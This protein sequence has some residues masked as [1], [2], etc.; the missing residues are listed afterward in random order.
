MYVLYRNCNDGSFMNNFIIVIPARLNSTRLPNKMM[1]LIGDKPV[2]EHTWNQAMLANAKK[3]IVATDDQSI[4]DHMQSVGA[5][6]VMTS[7]DHPTGTDRLAEVAVLCGFNDEDVIVN[8]Q[9]DEPFLPFEFIEKVANKLAAYPKA[10]MSTLATRIDSW[11]DFFNVNVVKVVHS[12][13]D[14]ALYFSRAPIPFPRGIEKGTGELPKNVQPLRHIGVYGYRAFF[15]KEYPKLKPSP[16]EQSESLE[17][18]RA[19]S[20]GYS[21]VIEHMDTIPPVGIDTAAEL[22]LARKW[23]NEKN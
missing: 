23:Y 10:A 11:E 2:I 9:G 6:V 17:Q 21:I 5:E 1:L 16:L 18:L 19:L 15:L 13:L 7:K 14:E 4:F 3:V 22:E 12:N 20:N 8:W